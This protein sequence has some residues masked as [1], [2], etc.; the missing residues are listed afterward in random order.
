M[1]KN[2]LIVFV[3]KMNCEKMFNIIDNFYNRRNLYNSKTF[4]ILMMIRCYDKNQNKKLKFHVDLNKNNDDI[5][6]KKS[7]KMKM[8]IYLNSLKIFR[9]AKYINDEKFDIDDNQNDNRKIK[10]NVCIFFWFWFNWFVTKKQKINFW[11]KKFCI[12]S[13]EHDFL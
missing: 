1:T 8:K 7:L 9:F 10:I 3:A 2:I 6:S 12:N 11:C 13:T 4:S 5:F